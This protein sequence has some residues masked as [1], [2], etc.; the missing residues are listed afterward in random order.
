MSLSSSAAYTA[1]L[2]LTRSLPGTLMFD[3]EEKDGKFLHMSLGAGQEKS[4]VI[5]TLQF[6]QLTSS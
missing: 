3:E 5:N 4:F 2:G 1:V 6:S